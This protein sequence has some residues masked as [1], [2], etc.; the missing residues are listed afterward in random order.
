MR[1]TPTIDT[2]PMI[3]VLTGRRP[4]L[5]PPLEL[6]QT[7]RTGLTIYPLRVLLMRK[8]LHCMVGILG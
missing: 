7:N 6:Q 1:R 4:H 2:L 5:I 3:L 8:D